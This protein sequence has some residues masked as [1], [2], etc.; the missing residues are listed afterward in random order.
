MNIHDLFLATGVAGFVFLLGFRCGLM[1][2]VRT[3]ERR[4]TKREVRS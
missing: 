4:T 1:S 3:V 2:A